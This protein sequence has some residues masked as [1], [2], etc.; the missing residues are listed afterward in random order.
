MVQE[1]QRPHRL[2]N[3]VRHLPIVSI[4]SIQQLIIFII[5]QCRPS[6][7]IVHRHQRIPEKHR[8]H[9]NPKPHHRNLERQRLPPARVP[10]RGVVRHEVFVGGCIAVLGGADKGILFLFTRRGRGGDE[11]TLDEAP[12]VKFAEII[13]EDGFYGQLGEDGVEMGELGLEGR[14]C[15]EDGGLEA[16]EVLGPE[17]SVHRDAWGRS[18]LLGCFRFSLELLFGSIVGGVVVDG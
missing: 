11:T 13:P 14:I 17:V 12:D 2:G 5:K 15:G 18:V 1:P 8:L 4:V 10:P 16:G 7:T 6:F 3:K 9:R